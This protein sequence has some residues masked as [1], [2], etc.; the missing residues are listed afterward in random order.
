MAHPQSISKK[1]QLDDEVSLSDA[2]LGL[3]ELMKTMRNNPT[4]LLE[5]LDMLKDPDIAAEVKAMMTD[6]KFQ[7]DMKR[8][9]SSPAWKQSMEKA[10]DVTEKLSQDP[11]LMKQFESQ[12]KR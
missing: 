8:F 1:S 3:S 4:D 2:E 5:T 10:K 11:V 9:T 6:P 12:F 7:E